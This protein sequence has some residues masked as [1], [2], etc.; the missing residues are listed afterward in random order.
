MY[1]S[2]DLRF[3]PSVAGLGDVVGALQQ[4]EVRLGVQAAVHAGQRF[5]HRG[6]GSGALRRHAAGDAGA[7][8][9]G[10]RGLRRGRHGGGRTVRRGFGYRRRGRLVQVGHPQ[11]SIVGG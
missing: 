1:G 8:A 4:R 11:P 10:G 2:P 9:A 7:D 3:W 5:E 6:D